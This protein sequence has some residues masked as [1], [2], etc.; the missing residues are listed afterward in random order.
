MTK[1]E[2]LKKLNTLLKDLNELPP[3]K[4]KWDNSLFEKWKRKAERYIKEIFEDK[5]G[6]SSEFISI[7][8]T[9][10][11][12]PFDI[13]NYESLSILKHERG[14]IEAKTLLESFIEEVN[15]WKNSPEDNCLIKL[16]Y[17]IRSAQIL[18]LEDDFKRFN[19]NEKFDKFKLELEMF[20]KNT[21]GDTSDEFNKFKK[22]R[23]L[24]TEYRPMEGLPVP[25]DLST[26]KD[27]L[28]ST[29]ILLETIKDNIKEYG[30]TKIQP[31]TQIIPETKKTISN[32][33]FIVHGHD[34]LAIVQVSEVLRKLK[35]EP[36][37]LKDEASKSNTIIEKIERLSS[38]VGF[39]IVLY[40][41]CDI[42]GKDSNS[43]QPRARQNVLLE[44]GYLMAKL[45]RENTLAL[46]KGNVETPSDIH[47]LVYIPMD[48]HKAWQYKL[49]DELKA[50]G[51]NVS[52]D[53]I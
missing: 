13:N 11:G 17:F 21:F 41:A 48:E 5:N 10:K 26:Y 15:E 20:L 19:V 32:K 25:L 50:S 2:A 47:G 31:T 18:T 29:K 43:L 3:F 9:F 40:T 49:V 39:G 44:H 12:S 8:Y 51:Y 7:D 53:N 45:G 34:E 28:N 16:N 35:L 30:L 36:I 1:T 52:K 46:K 42:A 4:N 22:I 33:V 6:Q 27:G 38:D 24:Y 23:F 37:I 14:R